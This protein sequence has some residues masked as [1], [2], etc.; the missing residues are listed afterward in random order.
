[1]PGRAEDLQQCIQSGQASA[2]AMRHRRVQLRRLMSLL[3][4]QA[5][6]CNIGN[7]AADLRQQARTS[8]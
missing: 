1:M 6:G 2:S 8:T 4:K 5:S 7:R 3:G